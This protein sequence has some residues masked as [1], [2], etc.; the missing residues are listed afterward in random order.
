M[1]IY[2]FSFFYSSSHRPLSHHS[3][4]PIS[5]SHLSETIRFT[6]IISPSL[7]LTDAVPAEAQPT[8][9]SSL[10]LLASSLIANMLRR[11]SSSTH[12][13]PHCPVYASLSLSLS[14]SLSHSHLS[15]SARRPTSSSIANPA[16]RSPQ[17]PSP[18]S[19]LS[20]CCD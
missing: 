14:L 12:P 13:K 6:L 15:F 8:V 2:F 4:A 5:P 19:C 20:L 10:S 17:A 3:Q 7:K 18:S 11:P 1:A 16:R 9:T